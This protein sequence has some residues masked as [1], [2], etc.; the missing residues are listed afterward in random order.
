MVVQAKTPSPGPKLLI[1]KQL[2][3]GGFDLKGTTRQ[4][5]SKV[6]VSARTRLWRLV[7]QGGLTAKLTE[8][9][10]L[11]AGLWLTNWGQC[12]SLYRVFSGG[13]TTHARGYETVSTRI[14]SGGNHHVKVRR[15]ARPPRLACR[16][17]WLGNRLTRPVA[18]PSRVQKGHLLWHSPLD[19]PGR[20]RPDLFEKK[21]WVKL[22]T[23]G[24]KIYNHI[25]TTYKSIEI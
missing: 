22:W 8:G 16:S 2:R 23:H 17:S 18:K 6:E 5:L 25:R 13:L 1:N 15:P 4:A 20:P 9:Q 12:A 10:T 11:T 24:D 21:T 14:C 19:K 7:S 3:Q